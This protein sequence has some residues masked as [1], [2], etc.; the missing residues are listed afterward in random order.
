MQLHVF[1]TPTAVTSVHSSAEDVYIIIDVIRATTTLSV[2]FEQGATRVLAADTLARAERAAHKVPGRLLCGERE[3]RPLP[4]FD[5]GNSP[6]QFS[7]TNLAGRELILTTTNG[8][9]AFFACPEQ[10]TR[11]AGSFYNAQ[12]VTARAL[13]I[14]QERNSNIALVCAGE[15]NYFALDDATCAG[16]LALELQRHYPAMQLHESVYA[17]AAL[18]HAYTPPKLLDYCSSAQTVRD[19]GLEED[20]AFCMQTNKSSR[21][22]MVMGKDPA[23]GLLV[24]EPYLA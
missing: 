16:Y 4:G 6:A 12:A 2:V 18:Y 3:A 11:L 10:S 15:L 7:Q 9:R 19:A 20:L 17:A 13:T 8:T 14:A 21:V 5:Y 23:T 24:I 22:P 1:F